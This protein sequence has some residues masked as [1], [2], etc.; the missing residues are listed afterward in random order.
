VSKN[1]GGGGGNA[2]PPPKPELLPKPKKGKRDKRKEGSG[3]KDGAAKE[4][5]T[6]AIGRRGVDLQL[7]RGNSL[8]QGRKGNRGRGER[9]KLLLPPE[10]PGIDQKMR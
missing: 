8:S 9:E 3:E 1:R 10:G 5:P 6:V 2:S 7:P 4:S